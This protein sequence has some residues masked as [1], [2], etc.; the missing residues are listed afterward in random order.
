MSRTNRNTET[1]SKELEPFNIRC[2]KFISMNHLCLHEC[3]TCGNRF[4]KRPANVLYHGTTDCPICKDGLKIK[5]L[6]NHNERLSGLGLNFE[7]LCQDGRKTQYRC[8]ACNKTFMRLS[9]ALLSGRSSKCP[10]CESKRTNYTVN[11]YN[12]KIKSRKIRMVATVFELQKNKHTHQCLTCKNVFESTP[13]NILRG[14]GC[15]ACGIDARTNSFERKEYLIGH[16]KLKLQGYEPQALNYLKSKG[17]D[18]R[19][20]AANVS[21]GKPIFKYRFK[22]KTCTYVPDFYHTTL[23][24]VIEVKSTWTFLS[25]KFFLRN[26]VKAKRVLKTHD[27]TIILLDRTGNRIK[28]PNRWYDMTRKQVAHSIGYK[29]A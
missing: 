21:E 19:K 27:F 11:T 17:C 12:G 6:S 28:I 20:I 1:Y 14:H 18:L 16:R 26:K 22:G 2:L 24:R 8:R 23:K 7:A 15:P 29:Y 5:L 10:H 4:E 9:E 13:D 25:Q 3:L